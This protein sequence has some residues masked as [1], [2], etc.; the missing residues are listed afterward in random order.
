MSEESS[1]LDIVSSEITSTIPSI[2]EK[3]DKLNKDIETNL[4]YIVNLS[5][6]VE[7][8]NKQIEALKENIDKNYIRIPE[9][10]NWFRRFMFK[11]LFKDKAVD[12]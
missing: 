11:L 5:I 3:M 7:K 8:Q 10:M 4:S 6:K 2:D 12:Q 1:I 9:H